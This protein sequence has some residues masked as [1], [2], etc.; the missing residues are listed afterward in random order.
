MSCV[1]DNFYE[2]VYNIVSQVPSG[3]VITYK[4]IA[5]LMG[6]PQHARLVG[7]ALKLVPKNLNIP[8]HRVVNCQGRLV[9]DWIEQKELLSREGI[10]FTPKGYV[11]MKRFAW[12]FWDWLK[13]K[14]AHCKWAFFRGSWQN[15]TAVNGFADR[16][17]TT[18]PRNP[19]SFEWLRVQRYIIFFYFPIFELI[20]FYLFLSIFSTLQGLLHPQQADVGDLRFRTILNILCIT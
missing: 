13:N 12:R 8:C 4:S 2:Q 3:T 11:D 14:K 9:P 1:L 7:R 17:L 10:L 16:C 19:Y 5:V 6:Y 15:R 18:R 20:F